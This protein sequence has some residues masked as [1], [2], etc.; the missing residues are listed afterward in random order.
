MS[1]ILKPIRQE[2]I[3]GKVFNVFQSLNNKYIM[4]VETGNIYSEAK[5]LTSVNYTYVETDEVIDNGAR[6]N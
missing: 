6:S 1:E 4:Q 3:N 5:D 2:V